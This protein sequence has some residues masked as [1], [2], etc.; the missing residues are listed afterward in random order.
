MQMKKRKG[1][2]GVM[3]LEVTFLHLVFPLSWRIAQFPSRKVEY[4]LGL[5][6]T[7]V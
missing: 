3:S 6:Q 2:I 5:T 4:E 1:A 7:I